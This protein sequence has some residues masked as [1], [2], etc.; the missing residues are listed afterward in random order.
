MMLRGLGKLTL[1]VLGPMDRRVETPLD[2]R[3]RGVALVI[4]LI[5]IV[6]MST[7]VVQFVYA[8]RVNT[9]MVINERDNLKSYYLAKSGM[10]LTRMLLGFQYALQEESRGTD[11]EM[12]QMIGRAMRRSNF[13]LYQYVDL[14]M[15]P[16]NSGSVEIPLASVDL[17]GMGVGGFGEFAGQFEVDAQPEEGRFD[18]NR[19]ARDE[20]EETELME[21]CSMIIDARYDRIFEEQDRYGDLIDRARMTANIVDFIDLNEEATI[22]GDECN[23]EGRAGD[24]MRPY[25]SDDDHDIEPRNAKLT[26][27]EELYRVHGVNEAFMDTFADEFTVYDVGR[28]NLNVARAPV[29]YSVLCRNL[30][31]TGDEDQETENRCSADPEVSDQVMYLAMALE[32]IRYFFDDPLSVMLAYVGSAQSTLLPSAKMGQPTAFL[33]VSQLPS[34][35]EDLTGEEE[36]PHLMAQFLPHSPSYQEMVAEDPARA[37][38]PINPQVPHWR[39]EFNRSGLMRSVTTRT[40]RVFRITATGAY[41]TSRTKIEAIVDYDKTL[42][43]L[44]PEEQ[45]F[46]DM[47]IELEA[48]EADAEAMGDEE[49]QEMDQMREFLEQEREDYPRGRV[50]YWRV[51]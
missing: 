25:L 21:F 31:F 14:L 38:D 22:I 34:Y 5:A 13:Q 20:I 48:L 24:E 36:G 45:M 49:R 40:P 27:V 11:D 7:A 46:A 2:H 12:G 43:R 3:P 51:Q 8:S 41:G 6:V 15:G 9:A 1:A 42:R 30:E 37:I 44:P 4:A 32:G 29:F 16:F 50:L 47:G 39:V 10:N 35:I 18:L 17:S 19:F 33:S 23:I 26:H 28:P